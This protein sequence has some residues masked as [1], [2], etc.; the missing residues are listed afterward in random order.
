MKYAFLLAVALLCACA[1]PVSATQVMVRVRTTT[2]VEPRLSTLRVRL[3][4]QNGASWREH[5][6]T[7]IAL[8]GLQWP[9]DLP[10]VRA[11][12]PSESGFEIVVEGLDAGGDRFVETRAATSFTPRREKLLELLLTDCRGPDLDTPCLAHEGCHGEKCLTCGDFGQ[13]GTTPVVAGGSLPDL[14]ADADPG[15]GVLPASGPTEHGDLEHCLAANGAPAHPF[16][17]HAIPYAAGISLPNIDGM[18]QGWS[19]LEINT[20][21]DRWKAAY[22]REEGCGPRE[23]FVLTTEDSNATSSAAHGQAMLITVW[24]AGYDPRARALF[25]GLVRFALAH[26]SEDHRALMAAHLDGACRRVAGSG[27]DSEGDLDIALALLLANKQ[28]GSGLIDYYGIARRMIDAILAT[29]VR[30]SRMQAGSRSARTDL[31]PASSFAPAHFHSF[32]VVSRDAAWS[33]LEDDGYARL[34][35]LIAEHSGAQLWPNWIAGDDAPRPALPAEL[36]DELDGMFGLRAARA[37]LRIGLRRLGAEEPRA[38]NLLAGLRATMMR[39]SDGKPVRLDAAY[40]LEARPLVDGFSMPIAA[41][42]GP[43][44]MLDGE[45]PWLDRLWLAVHH[46]SAREETFA[47][48]SLQLI[49]ALALSHNLWLPEAVPCAPEE[50]SV[51]APLL[52]VQPGAEQGKDATVLARPLFEEVQQGDNPQLAAFAWTWDG[53]A[54]TQRGFID[55]DLSGLPAGANITGA[56]LKLYA[57]LT[58]ALNRTGHSQFTGSNELLVRRITSPWDEHEVLASHQ[59]RTAEQGQLVHAKS[60]HN[61]ENYVLDVTDFVRARQLH[62]NQNFGFAL[63]LQTEA[64]YRAVT[65]ASSDH[66]D[67]A[68]HP[69]LEISYRVR[70]P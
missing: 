65:F 48:D 69:R 37:A 18:A 11:G 36:E 12:Q 24:L 56:T 51:A 28:W 33:R 22:V 10:V 57:E 60:Q 27:T 26:P 14:D 15:A 34:E 4:T 67:A 2:D 20:L 23:A 44:A 32:A 38:E 9:I 63:Q 39:A 54:G 61:S 29:D 30:A 42:L 13:C 66:P 55:F 59:P 68:L 45:Q 16:G 52:V 17:T 46:H 70:A 25:D 50:D 21:Y 19:D 8:G 35:Q 47:S 7:E 3:F 62:P 64:P 1:E 53:W 49:A 31:V 5:P 58:P 41:A 43:A 40:D 6:V